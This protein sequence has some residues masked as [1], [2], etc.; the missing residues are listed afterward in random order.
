MPKAIDVVEHFV[1]R[2]DWVDPKIT[3]DRVKAGDP[4]LDTD[5]CLVT[6]MPS[7]GALREALRRGIRLVVTH[8]PTFWDHYDDLSRLS[9]QGQDKLA[10]I[11]DHGLTIV[12]IHDTWDRW[13]KV[14]IPWAWAAFL[15][16]GDEPVS[17]GCRNYMHR[18]DIEATTLD[19]FAARVAGRCAAL[20]EPAVQVTGEGRQTVS[21]VGIGT[22][23]ASDVQ[24]YREMGCDVSIVS[25]DGSI[26]WREIQQASEVGHPVIRVN[27]GTSEEPGMV[28]LAKYINEHIDGLSAEH[29][30]H[31]CTYHPVGHMA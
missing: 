16:L 8:E 2:C 31:P 7:I 28:S 26:Y 15:G 20:G 18:Y 3:V 17:I 22:G 5:R 24:V 13:P 11:N 12:R 4:D 23:C 9:R 25:D 14:G 6:W 21:R 29:L 1:S 27:H 10:F 19:E 30:P